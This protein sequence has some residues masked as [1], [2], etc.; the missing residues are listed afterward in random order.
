M[1]HGWTFGLD[2][3]LRHGG[4]SIDCLMEKVC[5]RLIVIRDPGSKWKAIESPIYYCG[6]SYRGGIQ[7]A[8]GS[9]CWCVTFTIFLYVTQLWHARIKLSQF[10]QWKK[11]LFQRIS[12]AP[13]IFITLG[14]THRKF[15]NVFPVKIV[16][17]PQGIFTSSRWP[18][19][20]FNFRLRIQTLRDLFTVGR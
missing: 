12:Y 17:L 5:L 9:V 19:V 4:Y 2:I 7:A 3:Q 8:F 15:C 13:D 18:L 16:F 10:C 6:W 1:L 11:I 20:R 14:T